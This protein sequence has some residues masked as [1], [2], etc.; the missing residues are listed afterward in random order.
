MITIIICTH[1]RSSLLRFCLESFTMQTTSSDLFK[2]MVVDNASTDDTRKIVEEFG[3][4]LPVGYVYESKVGL[5]HTRNHGFREARTEWVGYVD[6]DAKVHSNFIER[7]LWMIDQFNFD[8][9]GGR[10]FPWYLEPKP[11][12]LSDDFGL[13]PKLREEPG[14]LTMTQHVAGGIAIFRR[15]ALERVK[16]FPVN[17]GMNGSEIGY[18]EENWTQ[19]EMRKLG[20]RIGFDPELKMD[21]LVASYKYTLAW[22]L[23]RMY[24]KGQ[25][26][27]RMSPQ[28]AKPGQFVLL[29]RA[30][31]FTGYSL[32][33]NL[34]K[35][36]RKDYYWQNYI[37]ESFGYMY[38]VIGYRAV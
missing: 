16:G 33:I 7:A 15:S 11:R 5:S 22:Q 1:N 35:F 12:W 20:F 38:K 25:T 10:F 32:L 26:E 6:D 18:G 14:E 24:A 28:K 4:R 34:M 17:L 29:V 23:R 27:R 21:H 30:I 8:C 2:I 31:V 9:F 36:T 37:L 19:D 13:F 3:S